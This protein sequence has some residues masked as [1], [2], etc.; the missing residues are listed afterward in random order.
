MIVFLVG[1]ARPLFRASFL[2]DPITIAANRAF[3]ENDPLEVTDYYDKKE[4]WCT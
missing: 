4:A 2:V 1:V 3:K